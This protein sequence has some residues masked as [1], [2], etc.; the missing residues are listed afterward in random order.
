MS[1][2]DEDWFE[3]AL[4]EDPERTTDDANPN[5]DADADADTD[6]D[7]DADADDGQ[8]GLSDFM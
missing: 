3:R 1:G 2:D 7:T 8:S 6:A 4:R 5:T